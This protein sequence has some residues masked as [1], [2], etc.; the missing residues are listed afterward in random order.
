M[1]PMGLCVNGCYAVATF[2]AGRLITLRILT[3]F[4]RSIWQIQPN[5]TQVIILFIPIHR[6]LHMKPLTKKKGDDSRRESTCKEGD[7][8]MHKKERKQQQRGKSVKI[9]SS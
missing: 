5:P 7:R 8:K 4:C 3:F 2:A 9:Q 6:L 1:G